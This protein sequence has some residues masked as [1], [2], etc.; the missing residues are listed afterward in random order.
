MTID[1]LFLGAAAYGFFMGFKEGIVNTIFRTLSIFLAL[2]AAFKFS[3]Y[4]TEI[5]EK[6]F[7]IYNPLMFIGGFIV[8]YFL[9]MWIMR[10]AGE[11]VTQVMQVSHVNIVNQV[12]GGGVLCLIFT[13]LF[14]IILWFG[15]S[16]R[17]I[18]P[19]TKM[20]SMSYR[21]LEPLPKQAFKVL[22][23]LKPTFQKF[24]Q[25][26]NRMM[27]EFQ[28]GRMKSSEAKHDIYSIPEEN[29]PPQTNNN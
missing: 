3:P 14:S 7:A 24:F 6:S 15:D 10:F 29:A 21:F 16:A 28:K 25:E 1:V 20:Q 26:T 19:E 9:C 2:M 17:M 23:D 18:T 22:G 8:T 5:L 27:D 12:V 4:V 11:A 13:V